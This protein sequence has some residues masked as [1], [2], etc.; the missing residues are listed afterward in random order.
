[1]GDGVVALAACGNDGWLATSLDGGAHWE[2]QPLPGSDGDT[3]AVA[4]T[5]FLALPEDSSL[6]ALVAEGPETSLNPASTD[7]WS[8]DRA[9]PLRRST[10]AALR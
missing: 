4:T 1:M 8:P 3:T 5:A 10:G 7:Q 2:T 6:G 9:A